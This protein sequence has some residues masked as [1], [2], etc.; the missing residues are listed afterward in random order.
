[1]ADLVML[2]TT[3]N[4]DVSSANN[5]ALDAKSS[6]KSFMYIR[7]HNGPSIEL[8]GTPAS[9][10]AHEKYWPFRR[11]LCFRGYKK[12]FTVFNNLPDMPFSLSLWRRPSFLKPNL[13]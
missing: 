4:D 7:K 10:T 13:I 6:D 1:M 11:T 12:S 2:S 5:F 8:C 9:I 3:D